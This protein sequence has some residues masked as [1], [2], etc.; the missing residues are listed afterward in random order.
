ML[1]KRVVKC[2]CFNVGVNP[3]FCSVWAYDFSVTD[4]GQENILDFMKHMIK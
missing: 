2:S 4:N 1:Y 3:M